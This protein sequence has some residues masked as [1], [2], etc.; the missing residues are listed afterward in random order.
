MNAPRDPLSPYR[1]RL[2][3]LAYR[4]LGSR[5]DAED[6]LQDTY[7]RSRGVDDIHNNEAFLRTVVTRLCLDRLKSSRVKRE[8]Y[9][10]PWLPEPVIDAEYLSPEVA[11]EL[12]DDLSFALLLTLDRLSPAER[13]AFLLHD[14]FALPFQEVASVLAR[15]EG[16]CRQ[17]ASRARKA[18]KEGAPPRVL[19]E[20][21]HER[22]FRVFM[23]ALA[24]GDLAELTEILAAD[25][26]LLTDS[27]GL[28]PSALNPIRGA[29]RIARLLSAGRRKAAPHSSDRRT[30]VR[31]INGQA[32]IISFSNGAPEHTLSVSVSSGRVSA[33]YL[34]RNPE[35]LGRLAS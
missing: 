24:S 27:G 25:A 17:L 30:E 19:S 6:V 35:K 14:V 3:G 32:S 15:S 12:A 33:V 1:G 11:T 34:V 31:R 7:L 29:E 4:M 16:A 26:V 13:A 22:V 9:V 23:L 10:G 5:A 21:K 2:L 20:A 28:P 18:V 8:L